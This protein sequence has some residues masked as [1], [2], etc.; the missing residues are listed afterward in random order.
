MHSNGIA[1]MDLKPENIY[2]DESFTLKLA[3]FDLS[4]P[5]KQI[6]EGGVKYGTSGYQAP[7]ILEDKAYSGEK[8]DVFALGVLLFNL[9]TGTGPFRN[10]SITKNEL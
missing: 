5:L 8:T 6:I 9:A 10:A 7:E 3:D 2:F 4:L 1:H